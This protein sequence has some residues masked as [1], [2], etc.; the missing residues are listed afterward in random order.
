MTSPVVIEHLDIIK[1]TCPG[2][3]P[4]AVNLS[5]YSLPL[6]QLE[7]ALSNSIVVAVT[8]PTHTPLQVMRLQK[9]VSVVAGVLAA[10]V[11]VNNYL[12]LRLATPDR[13][14]QQRIQCQL[15]GYPGLH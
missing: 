2:R 14:H 11:G 5:L 9:R 1:N 7:E 10:L 13:R 3:V 8:A 12:A 4:A 6:Q 15:L